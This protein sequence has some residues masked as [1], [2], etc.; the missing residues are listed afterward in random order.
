V[1]TDLIAG[2]HPES[3]ETALAEIAHAGAELRVS[4][5]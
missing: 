1:L 5:D 4:S 2:V 3:S